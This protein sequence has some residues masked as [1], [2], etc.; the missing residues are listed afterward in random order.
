MAAMTRTTTSTT[1]RI[2]PPATMS[3]TIAAGGVDPGDDGWC[4]SSDA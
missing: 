4:R 2:R 1:P 3:V